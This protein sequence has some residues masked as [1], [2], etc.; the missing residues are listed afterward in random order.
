MLKE[1]IIWKPCQS[2]RVGPSI[3]CAVWTSFEMCNMENIRDIKWFK[4][5]NIGHS[6]H[7]Y[8]LWYNIEIEI[9]CK[10]LH[11]VDEMQDFFHIVKW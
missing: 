7:D 1:R 6:I 8:S 4:K 5:K 9:T 10:G 2:D 11:I 3:I